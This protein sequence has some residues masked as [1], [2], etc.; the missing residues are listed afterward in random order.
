MKFYLRPK[1]R[2][3]S[4][5]VVQAETFEEAVEKAD[6]LYEGRGPW[7]LISHLPESEDR[8]RHR[9]GPHVGPLTTVDEIRQWAKLTGGRLTITAQELTWEIP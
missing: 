1:T 7:T 6:R 2:Y 4:P 5:V 3:L 8:P 9:P